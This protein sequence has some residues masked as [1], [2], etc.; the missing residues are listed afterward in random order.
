MALW[1]F[2]FRRQRQVEELYAEYLDQW[3]R[4]TDSFEK[5]MDLFLER[6]NSEEFGYWCRETHK[7]E[8]R[9]DDLRRKIEFELYSKA[10][11]PE[12]RGDVL[13]VLEA[14]DRV[15]NKV[16]SILFQLHLE[17]VEVPDLVADHFRRVYTVTRGCLPLVHEAAAACF[18]S[19]SGIVSLVEQ[20]DQKESECDHAERAAIRA[21]FASDLPWHTKFQL[22]NVILELGNVTDRA[23]G[24]SDRL[25]ITSVKRR[26]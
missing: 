5:A 23:E 9:A 17:N 20:I 12:S 21:L 24:A 2:L 7:H 8:S 10:L 19:R 11:L 25:L 6:G 15:I 16:E 22:K 13:A 14:V 4:C 1:D 26:V 3:K 18:K